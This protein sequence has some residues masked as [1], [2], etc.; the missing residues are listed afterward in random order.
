MDYI[1]P[2]GPMLLATIVLAVLFVVFLIILIV[3]IVKNRKNGDMETVFVKGSSTPGTVYLNT[4]K[5]RTNYLLII[6][7]LITLLLFI[8]VLASVILLATTMQEI[9]T[10]A[11][12]GGLI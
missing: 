1:D 12:I 10:Q 9:N 7:G 11:V 2:K 5:P 3:M 6:I 4:D 8:G